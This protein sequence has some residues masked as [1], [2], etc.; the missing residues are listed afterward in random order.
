MTPAS[1]RNRIH[2]LRSSETGSGHSDWSTSKALTVASQSALPNTGLDY[3]TAA[4][5]VAVK[6]GATSSS[7]T[8]EAVSKASS[9]GG[10]HK[11]DIAKTAGGGSTRTCTPTGVGGCPSSGNW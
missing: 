8:V 3:G 6:A 10:S 11:F 1:P 7:Y 4:G 2:S 9:G 5:Q